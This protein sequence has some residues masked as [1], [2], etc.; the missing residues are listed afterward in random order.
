MI[1]PFIQSSVRCLPIYLFSHSFIPGEGSVRLPERRAPDAGGGG[2][3]SA[4]APSRCS[5]HVVKQDENESESDE[6][7]V[8]PGDGLDGGARL[9]LVGIP[10]ADASSGAQTPQ[11]L[12]GPS[13][14]PLPSSFVSAAVAEAAAAV[15]AAAAA[16]SDV[17]PALVSEWTRSKA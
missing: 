4:R 8:E 17:A 15:A 13:S 12:P 10:S 7:N 6:G 2:G 1:H 5:T 16:A 3:E 11:R 14:A 9:V